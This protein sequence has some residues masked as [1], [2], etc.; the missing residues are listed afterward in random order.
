MISASICRSQFALFVA[1]SSQLKTSFP[2][3]CLWRGEDFRGTYDVV[4]RLQLRYDTCL[5]EAAMGH[6]NWFKK[7]LSM[8][9]MTAMTMGSFW[10]VAHQSTSVF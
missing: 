4:D 2:H 10:L 8:S 3:C 1:K 5:S 7:G 9:L 6:T